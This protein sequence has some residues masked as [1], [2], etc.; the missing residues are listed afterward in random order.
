M[1][2][3]C[4]VVKLS[5]AC[6]RT[7][8]CG[9]AH[10]ISRNTWC[11]NSL[12]TRVFRLSHLFILL[13]PQ[14][15][16][17]WDLMLHTMSLVHLVYRSYETDSVILIDNC[18]KS[19]NGFSLHLCQQYN[20]SYRTSTINFLRPTTVCKQVWNRQNVHSPLDE[21]LLLAYRKTEYRRRTDSFNGVRHLQSA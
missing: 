4:D 2:Q 14:I 5:A 19:G 16:R 8:V 21:S 10:Y 12:G 9:T 11:V 17:R 1:L 6:L 3:Q 20:K 18:A 13:I 7:V 15:W